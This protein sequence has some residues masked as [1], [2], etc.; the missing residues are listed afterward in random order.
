MSTD[1]SARLARGEELQLRT[2][3]TGL[4]LLLMISA[5]LAV[6]GL[7][8]V[9]GGD[10]LIRMLGIAVVAFF[11]LVGIPLIVRRLIR[12]ELALEVSAD[13]GVSIEPGPWIPWSDIRSVDR[14]VVNARPSVVLRLEPSGYQAWEESMV[15]SGGQVERVPGDDLAALVP[16]TIAASADQVFAALAAA[17]TIH[18]DRPGR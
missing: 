12:P 16:Q 18:R 1:H 13:R 15:R 14:E 3:R 17:Y 7:C 2:A 8:L 11:G 4:V 5:G 9:G 10:G 6:I